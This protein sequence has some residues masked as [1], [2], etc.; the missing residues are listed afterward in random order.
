MSAS[1]ISRASKCVSLALSMLMVVQ[2]AG[3]LPGS[4]GSKTAEAAPL[5]SPNFTP[6]K[7]TPVNRPFEPPAKPSAPPSLSKVAPP[8]VFRCERQIIYKG[9]ALNCDSNLHRDAENLRP[10]LHEVPSAIAEL[11][12]YQK[13]RAHV[14]NAAYFGGAGLGLVVLSLIGRSTFLSSDSGLRISRITT[15]SGALLTAGSLGYGLTTLQTNES[16]LTQAI[17]NFN[18]VHPENPIEIKF[19]T[20][21]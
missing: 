9:E 8:D 7:V 2:A 3:V 5:D 16:H 13:T 21:F 14:Q 1:T 6:G 15:F 4:V 18:Q 19:S 11:D 10:I 12:H 20:G 17:R